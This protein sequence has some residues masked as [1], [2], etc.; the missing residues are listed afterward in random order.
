MPQD[1]TCMLQRHVLTFIR[2]WFLV[3]SSPT[4]IQK[5]AFLDY[6]VIWE[7]SKS[8]WY[9]K[10]VGTAWNTFTK[11]HAPAPEGSILRLQVFLGAFGSP[12]AWWACPPFL[13]SDF[14]RSFWSF[15]SPHCCPC[16]QVLR[17]ITDVLA[18]SSQAIT[19]NIEASSLTYFEMSCILTNTSQFLFILQ[20]LATASYLAS[21]LWVDTIR[22]HM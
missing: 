9:H 16:W 10:H 1:K 22:S 12:D 20:V 19:Q 13:S 21:F 4:Q 2:T 15:C 8:F 5:R 14:L 6:G 17:S 7:N 11:T 3:C 18:L